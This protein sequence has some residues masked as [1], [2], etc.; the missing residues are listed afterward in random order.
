MFPAASV[1]RP[2]MRLPLGNRESSLNN[3]GGRMSWPYLA[4][5][6]YRKTMENGM[7]DHIYNVTEIAGSSQISHSDAVEKA[8]QRASQTLRHLAW[9]EV[10]E[11]RGEIEGGKVAHYQVIM[12]IGF[13]VED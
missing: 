6:V 2:V 12:K 9:F 11:Q 10:T 7:A 5:S 13:R 8:I 3:P 1:N 4:I